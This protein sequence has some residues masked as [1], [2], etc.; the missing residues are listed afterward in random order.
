MF[1]VCFGVC[2]GEFLVCFFLDLFCFSIKVR[3]F[4]TWRFCWMMPVKQA[5]ICTYMWGVFFHGNITICRA[6]LHISYIYIYYIYHI[7]IYI[8]HIS[9]IYIYI[10]YIIYIYCLNYIYH[11]YIYITYIIY[12][13]YMYVCT[14]QDVNGGVFKPEKAMHPRRPSALRTSTRWGKSGIGPGRY[15]ALKFGKW[16][17]P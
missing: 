6:F 9:Y 2:F 3:S 14:S 12:I 4:N 13:Y 8:L 16:S 7:Y 17:K 5:V 11:I 1:G 15:G 10:T